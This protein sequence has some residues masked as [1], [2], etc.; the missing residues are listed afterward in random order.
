MIPHYS[1]KRLIKENLPEGIL[2]TPVDIILQKDN[3]KAKGSD[4]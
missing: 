2:K 4:S 3:K 1:K